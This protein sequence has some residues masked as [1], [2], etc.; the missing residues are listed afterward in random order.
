LLLKNFKEV[1]ANLDD[2]EAY[3]QN[4]LVSITLRFCVKPKR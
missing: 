3:I 4:V 2:C 1:I